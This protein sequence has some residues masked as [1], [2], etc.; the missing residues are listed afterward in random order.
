MG[1]QKSLKDLKDK[2]NDIDK[3][4]AQLAQQSDRMNSL[5]EHIKEGAGSKGS[6]EDVLTTFCDVIDEV[7]ELKT[8]T[9]PT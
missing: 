2:E 6:S 8:I 7:L 4:L 1:L 9:G 5:L 3:L